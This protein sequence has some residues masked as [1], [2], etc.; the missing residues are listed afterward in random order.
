MYC[1]KGLQHI[2]QRKKQAVDYVCTVL[3]K[4]THVYT[5]IVT[6]RFSLTLGTVKNCFL[7]HAHQADSNC[8]I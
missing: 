3:S 8:K 2:V 5:Y 1:V 7:T 4:I 6:F